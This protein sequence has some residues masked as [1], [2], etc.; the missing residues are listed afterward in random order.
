MITKTAQGGGA[1]FFTKGVDTDDNLNRTEGWR[2]TTIRPYE[3]EKVPKIKNIL[4][5]PPLV[6][7][8]T[9]TQNVD[10]M[11]MK[12]W[13]EETRIDQKRERGAKNWTYKNIPGRQRPRRRV[14]LLWVDDEG[15]EKRK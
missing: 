9:I 3:A 6:R 4:E 2:K 8:E 11:W 12:N 13:P 14:L 5:S 1:L 15:D 10:K 7:N